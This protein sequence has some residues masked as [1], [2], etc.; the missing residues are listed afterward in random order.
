MVNKITCEYLKN[1]NQVIAPYITVIVNTSI[2]TDIFPDLWKEAI[3]V[4]THKK[5][6]KEHSP[7][8]RPIALLQYSLKNI[9]IGVYNATY[10]HR[11]DNSILSH[12]Q[13]GFR[14]GFS[15]KYSHKKCWT[16][17]KQCV[18]EQNFY[19]NPTRSIKSIW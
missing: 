12:N 16:T 10:K 9:G 11:I 7:N 18:R 15:S 5:W 6:D 17:D 19:I 3:V 1:V 14:L 8:Y 2:V 4:P 13:I